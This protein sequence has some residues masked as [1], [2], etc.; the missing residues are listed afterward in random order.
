MDKAHHFGW[1]AAT[2]QSKERFI[3][4]KQL[5]EICELPQVRIAMRVMDEFVLETL[6]FLDALEPCIELFWLADCR[7]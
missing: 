5:R 4:M 3:S 6:G 2:V 7:R 1:W